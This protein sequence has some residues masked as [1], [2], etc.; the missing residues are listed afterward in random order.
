MDKSY[1]KP[2]K[3]T[4]FVILLSLSA[5][6]TQSP[7]PIEYNN[8][9]L[10]AK[11]GDIRLD[12]EQ[13]IKYSNTTEAAIPEQE[14]ISSV[15]IKPKENLEIVTFQEGDSITQ[16]ASDFAVSENALLLA[17]RINN[18]NDLRAGRKL[19][20]PKIITHIVKENESLESIALEFHQDQDVL[21][22]LNN[23]TSPY[24]V[25]P[26][27]MLEIITEP[28]LRKDTTRVVARNITPEEMPTPSKEVTLIASKSA[29]YIMPSE[30]LIKKKF[31]EAGGIKKEG[32]II[33][34]EF[35]A[36]VKATADGQVTIV[37]NKPESFGNFVIIKHKDNTLSAYAHLNEAIVTKNQIVRKGEVIGHV[38][39]TGDISQA[40][41]YFALKVNNKPVDPLIYINKD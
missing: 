21:I 13:R 1:M 22:K 33:A 5:C 10:A 36:P 14:P 41:L 40:E 20:I 31:G 24:K 28:D 16:F 3:F 17:N 35:R 27:D 11:K 25:S 30:G 39:K 37:A 8:S 38:G 23:L 29:S 26:G 6:F 7:A 32:I 18:K 2:I 4:P 15:Q 9:S 19:I 12:S 34:T